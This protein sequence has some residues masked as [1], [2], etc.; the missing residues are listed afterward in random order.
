MCETC[1]FKEDGY[2]ESITRRIE[3]CKR[4]AIALMDV[5]D[6]AKFLD[7]LNGHMHQT[8]PPTYIKKEKSTTFG[9]LF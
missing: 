7:I 9:R 4:K 1:V 5:L 6:I 2:S 8:L 3:R